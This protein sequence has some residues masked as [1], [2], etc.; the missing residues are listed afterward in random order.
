M[1][2]DRG[3]ALPVTIMAMDESLAPPPLQQVRGACPHDCP[4]TCALVTT[5]QD[6][7]A[8]KVQGNPDHAPTAGVL[9]T[10]VSHYAERTNHPDRLLTPLKRIGRKGEGRFEPVSWDDALDAIATRLKSIAARDPQAIL[11]Y[12]YCGTMSPKPGFFS[13]TSPAV[14]CLYRP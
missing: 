2:V 8:L 11:P 5:V 10:K 12:S 14:A 7:R 3:R 9:C 4:D 1:P 13:V 6:G